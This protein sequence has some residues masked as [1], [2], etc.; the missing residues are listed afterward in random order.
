MGSTLKSSVQASCHADKWGPTPLVRGQ[1]VA[2]QTSPCPTGTSNLRR[3]AG[4]ARQ[5]AADRA[6]ATGYGLRATGHGQRQDL[7]PGPRALSPDRRAQRPEPKSPDPDQAVQTAQPMIRASKILSAGS[8]PIRVA[9][10]V[11]SDR[12]RPMGAATGRR[13]KAVPARADRLRLVGLRCCQDSSATLDRRALHAA[14]RMHGRARGRSRSTARWDP[15]SE[16]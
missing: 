13:P 14:T 12:Y 11:S 8:D 16:R 7:S 10:S 4:T 5:S 1:N 2:A 3:R 9:R 6:A 15:R